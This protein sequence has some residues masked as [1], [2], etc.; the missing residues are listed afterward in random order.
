MDHCRL[1]FFGDTIECLLNNVAAESVHAQSKRIT[2]DSLGNGNDLVLSTV[3]EAALNQEIAKT[4]DHEGIRLA[5]DG[6]DDL[7]LL[8]RCTDLKFLLQKNRGLLV[9]VAD[10][11]IHYVFPVAAHVAVQQTAVVHGFDRRYVLRST[12][13]TRIL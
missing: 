6:F 2:A 11:L 8:L 5:D 10:D 12:N 7:I 3:L 13:V 9:V 1:V 4:I